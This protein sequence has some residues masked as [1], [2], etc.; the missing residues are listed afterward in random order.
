MEYGRYVLYIIVLIAIGVL[1]EKY[2]LHNEKEDDE[3]QYDLVRKYLLNDSSLARSHLPTIWIHAS[4]EVNARWWPSFNSRN[5]LC[6]NQPYEFITIKSIIDKCGESFNV[7][8]IDDATFGKLM[9][10]WHVDFE[11]IAEPVKSKIRELAFARLLHTYGGFRVPASFLC[12]KD[13]KQVYQD[14]TMCDGILVG[15]ILNRSVSSE[16]QVFMTS[17][18][19][20]ACEKNNHTIDMYI[21]YLQ[22]MI[23][24]DYTAQSVFTGE[25][26]EWFASQKNNNITA[27]SASMLGVVDTEGKA[28]TIERLAGNSYI[29][30]SSESCGIYFSAQEILRR[31]AFQWLAR[32]SP[33]Q[34]LDSDTMMGK[35]LLVGSQ[36]P[37]GM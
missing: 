25:I 29:P 31:T 17:P 10:D 30:L 16:N 32:L 28:V 8:L 2:K 13:L 19:F 23:S 7:C 11:R 27:I 4:K 5:T 1:Y 34:V 35:A 3:R 37:Q 9:P 21:E 20:L 33:A 18:E 24:E 6:V 12:M 15:E 14:A 26:S 36:Q 22:R